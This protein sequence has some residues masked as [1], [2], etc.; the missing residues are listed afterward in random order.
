MKLSPW[1]SLGLQAEPQDPS[2]R[3]LNASHTA[4]RIGLFI[5]F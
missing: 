1:F 4:D 3:W 5:F 2:S